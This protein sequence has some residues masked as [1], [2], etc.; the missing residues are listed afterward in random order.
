MAFNL[1]TAWEAVAQAIPDEDALICG[2][3]VRSWSQLE[4]RASRLAAALRASS[5]GAGQNVGLCL[6]NGNEYGEAQ[7]GIMKERA[8]PFNVNYRYTVAE[9]L[10]LLVDA[11]AVA[12][13]YSSELRDRFEEI[14]ALL[15][16]VRLFVQVGDPL[17]VPD[18]AVG[19][20]DLVSAHDPASPIERSADDVWLLFTGGTT[21][22]PKGVMWP[23]SSL[24]AGSMK[25]V[26][27]AMRMAV[28]DTVE[29]AVERVRDIHERGFVTRQLAAAPLMHGT[30]G[31]P[32][33]ATYLQGGCIIT[34]EGHSFDPAEL[35][36]CV[37]RHRSTHLTIVGDAFCRPMVA[38]LDAAAEAGRP[39]D[40]SSVFLVMSSGVMWSAPTKAALLAHNPRMKLLDAVGSSEGTGF[41]RKLEDD[42]DTASTARFEL[43]A[44]TKVLTEDG[45]DVVPGSGERGQLALA[46][47]L[48]LGYYKDPEKTAE[49][50]REIDGR[51]YSIPG[52]WATVEEDGTIVLLGRG[53][54]SINT[55]GE[56]VYPEEVEEAL[57]LLDA[58]VD[59]N[60]VGLPDDRWGQAVAAVVELAPGAELDETDAGRALREHL[61]SYKA[62]KHYV[63]VERILRGP[64]GKPDYRWALETAKTALSID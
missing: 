41:A 52:D 27:R 63:T 19:Y 30:S 21:G 56:K 5:V 51:R 29:E 16:D 62:P 1:A 13:F 20:E 53:S 18:F 43:G 3:V 46:G 9:L 32:S 17:D 61:A 26:Y 25:P 8:W 50:F 55:G 23:H 47:A 58:I 12:V 6:F 10:D 14:H 24:V 42:A 48:P 4:D 64:N 38:E 39:Y 54:V 59:A 15:P 34:L 31:I 2:G 49:T 37:E 40:L 33:M 60:V 45:R 7:F 22:K 35:W 44:D 11:D 57:K 28:P 36:S